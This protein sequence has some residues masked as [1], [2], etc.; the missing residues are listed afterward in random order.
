MIRKK[1]KHLNDVFGNINLPGSCFLSLAFATEFAYRQ[2]VTV[3]H[4]VIY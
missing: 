3:R 2:C 1:M 4:E